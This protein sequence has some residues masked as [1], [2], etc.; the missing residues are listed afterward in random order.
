MKKKNLN[1]QQCNHLQAPTARPASNRIKILLVMSPMFRHNTHFLASTDNEIPIG[2]CYLAAALEKVGHSVKIFD[3]QIIP[4]AEEEFENLLKNENFDAIGF[5]VVSQ[6]VLGAIRLSRIA[7]KLMPSV[8]I[9]VGGAQPTVMG[10][11]ILDEM[12]DIDIAVFGEGEETITELA[13]YVKNRKSLAL[14]QGIAYKSDGQIIRTEKRGLIQDID[15]IPFPAYHLINIKKYTPPPGL[16]F[17]KPIVGV[18]SA[19][20]CPFNCNFCA[21]RVI[22]QGRCRL[23]KPKCVL[24][25]IEMLS[26]K[27]GVKEIKFFDDTFTINRTRTI[28]ICH[29][30]LKRKLDII[31]RCASRVDTVDKELLSLM[32]KSGCLSISFGIESGSDEILKK[33]DKKITT[34]KVKNAVKWAKEVGMETKGF[35]L[36]NY[37]GDTIETT[38]K[39]I[40]FSRELDLDFAGFN[41]IFPFWGTKVREEIEQNYQI[42]K[43]VWD[44]WNAPLGNVIFFHQPQLSDEY[45]KKAYRRAAYG[46]YLRPK[47]FFKALKRIRNFEMLKS[48]I[49]GA[50]R[51]L[52]L[53]MIK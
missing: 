17:R 35:F 13:Q 8:I 16:F 29:E 23:R 40:A 15:S 43:T 31:W 42:E 10:E 2:L 25:E 7:K 19:R 22:W 1:Y 18:I 24:D 47:I 6:A 32:K 4:A 21:D 33:M 52:K 36:L 51:L 28:A 44:N 49:A 26:K 14:I 20:G 12:P 41:L 34:E 9:I 27:Y 37:P 46:F 53:R 38:E 39:T 3:G 48:Y 11:K 30:L 5:S 50:L 45:L